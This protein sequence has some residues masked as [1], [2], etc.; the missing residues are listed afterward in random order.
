MIFANVD[1]PAPVGPTNATRSRRTSRDASRQVGWRPDRK[2][3]VY[4]QRTWTWKINGSVVFTPGSVSV[5]VKHFLQR[6]SRC[7]DGVVELRQ[8]L[9]WFEQA[10][11]QQHHGDNGSDRDVT[12]PDE[13]PPAKTPSAVATTPQNSTTP[14]YHVDA[15][16]VRR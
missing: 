11:Q 4:N 12:S 16:T 3:P 15:F 9:Q 1:L 7:L 5:N 6:S 14:K 2:P 13:P 10:G 8:L